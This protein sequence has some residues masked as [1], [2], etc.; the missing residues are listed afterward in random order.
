MTQPKAR[1]Q[2]ALR[3]WRRPLVLIAVWAMLTLL[4]TIAGPFGTLEALSLFGRFGYWSL[5]VGL[6][7]ISSALP[8]MVRDRG[9]LATVGTWLAYVAILSALILGLNQMFFHN[10]QSWGQY[11]YLVG[12]VG[13]VVVAVHVVIWAFDFARPPAAG[14]EPDPQARF[15]RRLPL[16]K[17]AP[18]VRIEAQDHYLNVVTTKGSELILM[19]LSEAVS[20]LE[21]VPGLLVHRSH[22][23]ALAGVEGHRRENGRDMLQMADGAEVPVSRSN[24][25]AAQAAG[26]F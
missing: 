22:W 19:R 25:A 16:A 3:E 24:R 21:N 13:A 17:R 6:S 4:C 20:D 8:F 2:L 1:L 10:W 26:L 9:P 18:L 11:A 7:V 14:D 5:A 15:L 12:V 23:V